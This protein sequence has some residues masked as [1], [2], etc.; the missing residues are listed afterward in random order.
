MRPVVPHD[1]SLLAIR[2]RRATIGPCPLSPKF[3]ILYRAKIPAQGSLAPLYQLVVNTWQ[4][5]VPVEAK[6][7]RIVFQK[8]MIVST[9]LVD[10]EQD[11]GVRTAA[12][13]AAYI[14][15]LAVGPADDESFKFG[16]SEAAV[17]SVLVCWM[18]TLAAIERA[19]RTLAWPT[20]LMISRR[21]CP[22]SGW[23]SIAVRCYGIRAEGRK[24]LGL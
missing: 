16:D 17:R 15:S 3:V 24:V 11:G 2:L 19:A 20:L 6:S 18:C 1:S 7:N 12:D 4:E 22:K 8:P 14:E 9:M 5:I 10:S 23:S 13:V 21:L